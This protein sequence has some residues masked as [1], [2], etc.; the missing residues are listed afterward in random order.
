MAINLGTAFFRTTAEPIDESLTL[1]KAQMLVVNDSLMPNK[2]LTVC[3]DDGKVYTYDKN[4]TPN[5]ETGKFS[6]ASSD[7]Y[8]DT[9]LTARVTANENAIADMYTKAEVDAEIDDKLAN[10]DKLDYK[11]ADSVPTA[12]EVMIGGQTVPVVEG[13]RYWVENAAGDGYDEWVV[14]SGTV[15]YLGRAAGGAASELETDLT[16][17]NPI[18]KLTKDQV[19]PSGSTIES[20][21]RSML[22]QTYYPTLTPPTAAITFTAPALAKVGQS[23]SSG[24]ATVS[25]DRGKI[26]PKY[27]S[28]SEYRAGE[29][30]GYALKLQNASVPFDENNTTGAFTVPTFTKDSKGMVTLLATVSHAA[31][32][33]PKDSDGANYMSPLDAGDVTASK[34]V[35]FILPMYYGVSTTE[36]IS[37]FTGFTEVLRKKQNTN[38]F[39]FTTENQHPMFAYDSSYGDLS[40]ILD[41]NN[42]DFTSSFTASTVTVDGQE[43]KVY[44][45]TTPTTDTNAKYT[46]KF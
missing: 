33:Q 18:G 39:L 28:E 44:V 21:L 9:A 37:G 23:I 19:L 25:F 43:Y 11:V 40:L 20:I 10:F 45:K 35:E 4:A 34:N 5:S 46:F 30:T 22:S 13:L 36:M 16:V 38:E 26:D 6:L 15:R 42:Y 41:A 29:A 31:G 14:M 27:T 8:D 17:S 7:S 1:T 24:N 3:Q 2:Y 32:V 12:T